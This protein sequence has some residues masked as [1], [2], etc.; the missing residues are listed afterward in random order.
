MVGELDQRM[1]LLNNVY[2]SKLKYESS[3]TEDRTRVVG[4]S[5]GYPDLLTRV[6]VIKM[7][8]TKKMKIFQF[9]SFISHHQKMN[10]LNLAHMSAKLRPHK[11]SVVKTFE[12]TFSIVIEGLLICFFSRKKKT[13]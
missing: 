9:L 7:T 3:K 5:S 6:V 2:F 12:D 13:K 10:G 11:F 8:T 4:F 1:H